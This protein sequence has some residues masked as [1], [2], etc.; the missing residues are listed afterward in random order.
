M[1]HKKQMAA[2][3][4]SAIVLCSNIFFTNNT[5]NA[6]GNIQ[7]KLDG[8]ILSFEVPPQIINERT[9]VPFRDIGEAM[10]A[11]VGWESDQRKITMYLHNRYIIIF[12]GNSIMTYGEFET[13]GTGL[14]T[15]VTSEIYTLDA[16][17]VIVNNRTLVPAR[18]ISEGLGAIV[19]W[20]KLTSTVHITSPLVPSSTPTPTPLPTPEPTPPPTPVPTPDTTFD[21]T[22]YFEEISARRAQSMFDNNEK[23]V[24]VYY[25]S[26]DQLSAETL[27]LIKEA[28]FKQRERIYGVDIDTKNPNFDNTGN[29]LT[30]ILQYIAKP[31]CPT[32]FLVNGKADVLVNV[33]PNSQQLLDIQMNEFWRKPI[34]TAPVPTNSTSTPNIADKTVFTDRVTLN[35]MYNRGDKFIYFYYNSALPDSK[36]KTDRIMQA[37]INVG[38]K[39]Y[40]VDQYKLVNESPWGTQFITG[41]VY[42]PTIFYITGNGATDVTVKTTIGTLAELESDFYAFK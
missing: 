16:A 23:F 10:G 15:P 27:P 28:A 32:I 22:T 42:F 14:V 3:L 36:E 6:A 26:L 4:I 34:A 13:D 40:A 18:A 35:N 9:M 39:I 33:K 21:N 41:T 2:I 20:E 19:T 1:K 12:I 30:F 17:P 24:L 11:S 31:T 38:I 25:S 37:A 29:V 5:A 8:S 7:V